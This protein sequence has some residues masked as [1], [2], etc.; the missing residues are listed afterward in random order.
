MSWRGSLATC[1]AL[2]FSTRRR[3]SA[4]SLTGQLLPCAGLQRPTK[5]SLPTEAQS[6]MP[7]QDRSAVF[8]SISRSSAV[9]WHAMAVPCTSTRTLFIMQNQFSG[10]PWQHSARAHASV[11]RCAPCM[12][13]DRRS[14]RNQMREVLGS[15]TVRKPEHYSVSSM[16][17]RHAQLRV[18]AAEDLHASVICPTKGG[19]DAASAQMH[20][21][22]HRSARKR[23]AQCYS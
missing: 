7:C 21:D 19:Q 13:T 16:H 11:V 4:T 18:L 2:E 15:S 10:A 14:W 3:G 23:S 17:R 6:I 9:L 12:D 20:T 8:A 5:G 1:W 22:V